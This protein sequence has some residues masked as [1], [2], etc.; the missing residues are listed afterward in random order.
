MSKNETVAIVPPKHVDFRICHTFNMYHNINLFIPTCEWEADADN[1]GKDLKKE[2][3]F[4]FERAAKFARG[5][6]GLDD[7]G[8]RV[9]QPIRVWL[10][11]H[12][13]WKI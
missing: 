10:S 11:H 5:N 1:G 3:V 6:W 4:C 13:S 12:H 8:G 9:G 2:D 7:G